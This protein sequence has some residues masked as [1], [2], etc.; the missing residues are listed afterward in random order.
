MV[1]KIDFLTKV[2]DHDVHILAEK[3]V[4]RL[5]ITMYDALGVEE[6]N[7]PQKLQWQGRKGVTH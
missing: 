6:L 3:N 7:S 4:L 2:C 1:T 5:Q